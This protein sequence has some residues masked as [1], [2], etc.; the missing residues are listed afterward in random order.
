[1]FSTANAS[2]AKILRCTKDK[3]KFKTAAN[4]KL[5]STDLPPDMFQ[6]KQRKRKKHLG[7]KQI[8]ILKRSKNWINLKYCYLYIEADKNLEYLIIKI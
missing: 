2:A 3:R 1:L 4:E 5:Q 8:P 6:Q 7:T